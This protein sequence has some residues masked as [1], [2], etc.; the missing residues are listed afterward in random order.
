MGAIP[1]TCADDILRHF[2]LLAISTEIREADVSDAERVVLAALDRSMHTD[3][4]VREIGRPA[5]EIAPLLLTLEL[6]GLVEAQEG[7]VF[8]RTKA[9]IR[10]AKNAGKSKPPLTPPC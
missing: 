5:A 9:G 6:K 8:T 3:D 10:A 4:V 7:N 1:C 2:D